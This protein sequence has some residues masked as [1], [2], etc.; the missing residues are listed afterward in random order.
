MEIG[1]YRL[2]LTLFYVQELH[3]F[4]NLCDSICEMLK[5]SKIQD[6]VHLPKPRKLC[7][8]S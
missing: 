2:N 8:S 6:G 3:D 7:D 1:L 5:L 4:S